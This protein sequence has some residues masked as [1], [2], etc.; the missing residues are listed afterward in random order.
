[1]ELWWVLWRE[2]GSFHWC[3]LEMSHTIWLDHGREMGLKSKEKKKK[4]RYLSLGRF[5][6]EM[7]YILSAVL[8]ATGKVAEK[9][10]LVQSLSS[11]R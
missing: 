11:L 4:M 6:L 2:F 3:L 5:L 8:L 7:L 1:M 10:K 9:K